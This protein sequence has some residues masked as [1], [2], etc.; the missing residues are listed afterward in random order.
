MG[1]CTCVIVIATMRNFLSKAFS[2]PQKTKDLAPTKSLSLTKLPDDYV[3]PDAGSYLHSL[4]LS[5]G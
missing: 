5:L 3:L 1:G 4:T 2:K